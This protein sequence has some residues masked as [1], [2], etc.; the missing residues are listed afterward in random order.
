M[1]AVHAA[2]LSAGQHLAADQLRDL[3]A[4]SRG[5]V[6]IITGPTAP[7]G[8][9]LVRFEISIDCGATPTA[10]GG[11]LLR[12]RER[13]VLGVP[14][15]FPFAVPTVSLPHTRWAGIPHVQ[16]GRVVCLYAAPSVQW[17]PTDGMRALIDQLIA[18]LE[19]A[20]A[21]DLD[22]VDLPL[23]PPVAY[24]RADALV[25]V[26]SDLPGPGAGRYLTA[27]CTQ[28]YEQRI[29]VV[30]W[31][32]PQA[33][34][35]RFRTAE[36]TGDFGVGAARQLGASAVL[37]DG[38]IGFE[39]PSG[40]G[41]LL[42]GLAAAGIDT[43]E[44]TAHL[45]QTARINASLDASPGNRAYD[46]SAR[47]LHLF[48]GTPSR[49]VDAQAP[50]RI[51]LVCWR[52]AAD[53]QH[54]LADPQ[55]SDNKALAWL[56]DAEVSWVPVHEQRP[57][58]TRRRDADSNAA[59][60]AGK[61]VL[62]LGCGAL[63]A[64][65]AESC[66]RADA[67]TV[68]LADRAEVT[69]GILVRQPYEDRDIGRYKSYVLVER[70]NAIHGDD[71]AAP[72]LPGDI[73]KVVLNAGFDPGMYDLIIDAA[74]DT[75]VTAALEYR[76]AT[77]P[78]PWPPILTTIIG[79]DARRG[80]VAL[81][82]PGASGAG[83]DTL[84][85][86]HLTIAP[87]HRGRWADV[88]DDF[89]PV[90]PRTTLFQP[91]PGCSEPTYTGS[92]AEANALAS[93]LLDAG[94][95]ALSERVGA[96]HDRHDLMAA[97]VRLDHGT[98]GTAWLSWPN[99]VTVA[100]VHGLQVRIAP[101]ALREMRAEAVRGRRL[102][103]RDVETGGMLIGAVDEACGCA[104]IDTATGPPPDSIL[105]A[106]RF[107][108][109]TEGVT[110]TLDHHRANSGGQSAF[111]GTWHTHP[112]HEARPSPTDAAGAADL[113]A[114]RGPFAV[115]RAVMLILGGE[116]QQWSNWLDAAEPPEIHADY[117]RAASAAEDQDAPL[118]AAST[119]VGP[120][121]PGGWRQ[122]PVERAPRPRRRGLR[123]L[124]LPRVRR[125]GLR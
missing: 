57:E 62:V 22:P 47:P 63:G 50:L 106:D 53:G 95:Q 15:T 48:I 34:R 38:D 121:W 31:S 67:A 97:A 102:R 82:K 73:V 8:E 33:W 29:D 94:A 14:A 88:R 80:L 85:K 112:D 64:P 37:L 92:A 103:G 81:A 49:R 17:S 3:A 86:L 23:H 2:A 123:G 39:Y 51:H 61:R 43:P 26:R 99:D 11:L 69:P 72:T 90:A 124:R 52:F 100:A 45:R 83:R 41:D 114:G 111:T 40:G 109:G 107:W 4:R 55:I 35:Q 30:E 91:E 9:G 75:A 122:R 118:P 110:D 119:I 108:Y 115:P 58:V 44:L 66:V 60:I 59:W 19:R 20:A 101:A 12:P 46:A 98:P 117:Y 70:L 113:L 125:G 65:I 77:I 7:D 87:P 79:H 6:E 89:F 32:T 16:W 36:M 21:G 54:L 13:F 76:R 18:W 96:A 71:R 25:V 84:R 74:A 28:R 42:D 5:A 24:T 56:R 1:T 27:V 116:P 78:G 105:A 68:I 104:W 120:T 93:A 10:P